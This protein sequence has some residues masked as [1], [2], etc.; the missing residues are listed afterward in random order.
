MRSKTFK[1]Y[2]KPDLRCSISTESGWISIGKKVKPNQE[3]A[4]SRPTQKYR[5]KG[6][7]HIDQMHKFFLVWFSVKRPTVFLHRLSGFVGFEEFLK[8]LLGKR[9]PLLVL[10]TLFFLYFL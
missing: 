9:G 6:F 5:E 10:F 2:Y 8:V 4:I 3:L 7:D 1:T